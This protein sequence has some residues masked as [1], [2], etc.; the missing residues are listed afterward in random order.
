MEKREDA[1]KY[2]KDTT[3]IEVSIRVFWYYFMVSCCVFYFLPWMVY[4]GIGVGIAIVHSIWM[5][6]A[7]GKVNMFNVVM[8]ILVWPLQL[9]M[10]YC[11]YWKK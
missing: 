9:Y 5:S 1:E 10:L 8:A 4:F 11:T 3:G 7:E 2:I 6:G